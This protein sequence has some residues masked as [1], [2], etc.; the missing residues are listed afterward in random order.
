MTVRKLGLPLLLTL[1]TLVVLQARADT[2]AEVEE[3]LRRDITYL[4]SAECEGRGIKT[5][6]INLAADYIV[7]QFKNGGLKPGGTDGGWFQHF[8][9]SGDTKAGTGHTI[10]LQG[11][12]GQQI[13]LGLGAHFQPL[14]L[15][16]KGQVSAPL[17]F[18]GYGITA[19]GIQYDDYSGQSVAG[20]VAVMIRKTPRVDHPHVPFDGSQ[21]AVHAG[22]ETKVIKADIHKAAA[23]LLLNDHAT[24]AAGDT[25]MPFAYTAQSGSPAKIPVVHVRRNV[26]EPVIQASL[27]QTLRELEQDIDRHLKPRSAELTGWTANLT[28]NV[29]R[30]TLSLKNVIGVVEGV[31]KLANETIVIG[32]H[33]DHLGYGDPRFSLFPSKTPTIHH[34]ADDNGSGTTAM[35]ELAR[36]FAGQKPKGDRRR[37]VFMAFSAEES[38]LIGSAY[39]CRNPLF[40]LDK[41]AAMVNLDMVGRLRPDAETKRDRLYVEGSGTAKHFN[42]LLDQWAKKHDFQMSKTPGGNGPSDHAS[43]YGVK[44]PVIFYWTGN[45]PDYHRPSDTADKINIAGMRKIV[46]LSED[47][48]THLATAAERPEFVQIAPKKMGGMRTNAPRLGVVPNY[49]DEK[50]GLLLDGVT[51]GGPAQKA[52]LKEG[53]RILTLAGKPV[54]NVNSYMVL[55]G[56]RKKGETFEVTVDRKGKQ[57]TLKVTLE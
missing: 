30:Q 33:Y 53:D 3:R 24:A 7:T 12:L 49:A 19:Q 22:L 45:H 51:E 8:T 25:L 29:E 9:M 56:E 10:S 52:G 44:I 57:L 28:I 26:L 1:L 39:Y 11:P 16:G 14:G 20:K 36:R 32:A 6:G 54:R 5:K 4:A 35:L 17:V 50:D 48:I 46:A 18:V 43:F 2:P 13:D 15:S 41:T 38:G 55:M 21:A 34:G 37:L 42:E 27:G 47:T 40:P 31:G 23:I